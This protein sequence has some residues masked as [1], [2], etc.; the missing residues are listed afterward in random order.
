MIWFKSCPRCHGDLV[1]RSDFYG[2]Y[3]SCLQ[4]GAEIDEAAVR[5][6]GPA[7]A[8]AHP[9][10]GPWREPVALAVHSAR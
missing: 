3:L 4:C 6:Q 1:P 7:R 10:K 2:R 5:R 9:T 8:D